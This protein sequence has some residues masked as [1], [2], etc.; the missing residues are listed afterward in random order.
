MQ[1]KKVAGWLMAVVLVAGGGVALAESNP[2]G[3]SLPDKANEHATT[4]VENATTTTGATTTTSEA[5]EANNNANEPNDNSDHGA[6]VSAA[7]QDH[8]HDAECGNHGKYVSAVAHGETTCPSTT[9]AAHTNTHASA[10]ADNESDTGDGHEAP[11]AEQH[12]S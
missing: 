6:T 9:I 2:S 3:P 10:G 12:A 8:S 5:V 11:E 1:K 4:A 7:A